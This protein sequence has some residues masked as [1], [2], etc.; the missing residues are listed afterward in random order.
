MEKLTANSEEIN[1]ADVKFISQILENVADVSDIESEVLEPVV[2]TVNQVIST[3]SSSYKRYSLTR[4]SSRV[5]YSVEN[6]LSNAETSG[7][8]IKATRNNIAVTA[9]PLNSTIISAPV[10]GVLE[11]WGSNITTIVNDSTPYS[12]AW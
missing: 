9:V 6:I 11:N 1:S 5:L 4:D 10:S 2:N 7:Q 3:I 12:D 8:V